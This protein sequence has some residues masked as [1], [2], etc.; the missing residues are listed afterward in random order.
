V[1]LASYLVNGPGDCN[2]CHTRNFDP[3]LPGGN[4]FN[5]EPESINPDNYLVGGS[6]FGGIFSRNLRPDP[7]TGRPAGYR[8][9]SS[10][11]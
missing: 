9:R 2:G 5:G 1:G 10:G 8:S 11:A 6:D 7:V 3:Y 4:P